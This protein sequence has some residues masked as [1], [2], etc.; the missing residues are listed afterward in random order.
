[1]KVAEPG[2]PVCW[3]CG[4]LVDRSDWGAGACERSSQKDKC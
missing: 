2:G 1:M 4:G 3:Q